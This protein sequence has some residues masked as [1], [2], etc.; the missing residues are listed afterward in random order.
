[1][2]PLQKALAEKAVL[3]RALEM[4]VKNHNT[5]CNGCELFGKCP[6][7]TTIAECHDKL[8]AHFKAKAS[9]EVK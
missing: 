1:M 2:T 6:I 5:G 7:S 9:E 4:A 3:E 8:Y